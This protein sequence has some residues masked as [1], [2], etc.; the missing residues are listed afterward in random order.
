MRRLLVALLLSCRAEPAAAPEPITLNGAVRFDLERGRF[1]LLSAGQPVMQGATADVLVDDRLLAFDG[2]CQRRRDGNDFF[3]RYADVELRLHFDVTDHIEVTLDARN[4]GTS[5]V[6]IKRLTPVLVDAERGGKLNIGEPRTLR[7]LEN[8]RFIAIDQTAQLEAGDAPRFGLAAFAPIELRGNSVSNWSQLLFDITTKRALVSGYLTAERAIP[9]IGVTG[10]E[11]WAAESALIFHGK[12][13]APGASVASERLYLDLLPAD[14][15]AAMERYADAL[16]AAN[17]AKKW[18]SEIPCG[19]NSWSGGGGTGGHGQAI[20]ESIIL[21][22]LDIVKRELRP[23]GMTY[24]QIDD[25]W[26]RVTGDWTWDPTK[27]PL[28]GAGMAKTIADAGSKPGLWIAPFT[29][30]PPAP[31]A[32]EHPDWLMRSEE[33]VFGTVGKDRESLDLSNPAVQTHL[34]SVI[35]QIE[36]DGFK[37][38]KADFTYR[39]LVGKHVADPELT[40]VEAFRKGWRAIRDALPRDVFLLGIGL[41]GLHV[42]VADGM[43]MT[44]DDG[45]KWDEASVDDVVNAP[46]ALKGS[47]RTGARRWFYG[48]RA[49]VAHQDLI[50]FRSWPTP[51]VPKLTLDEA[52]T[53][54]TWVGLDGGIVEIGDKLVDL[55][56]EHLDILR[57]L[58][59]VWPHTSRPIDVL[60]R[61]Y[62]ERFEQTIDAPIGRYALLGLFH[63]GKNRDWST[64][65]PAVLSETTPREHQ[66]SCEKEC[67]AWE[68]WTESF[69]GRR[70]GPFTV[71]VP[72]KSARVVVLRDVKPHPQLLATNRHITMGATDHAPETWK[73]NT[74]S[75]SI[76]AVAGFEYHLAFHVPSGLTLESVE[77]GT[78]TQEGEIARVKVTAAASAPLPYRL[79]FR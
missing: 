42:G 67:L 46:R 34:R 59:P 16:A 26:Q 39:A 44:L 35:D 64:H 32:K 68:F 23:F 31:L 71:S 61:D 40:N 6:T 29:V 57:R 17:G 66:V 36:R 37:W 25:G 76:Q 10:N 3:C 78:F 30:E 45:P 69:L 24:F 60:L 54:A 22:G 7:I 20:D 9:T 27:F 63:W 14:P 19:W 58:L 38:V 70:T 13:I 18:A 48:N 1:D 56:P 15:L 47:V 72:P 53:F 62:P 4:V 41:V 51:E 2:P 11:L 55:K 52:R 5:K 12:P 74:L 73:D 79:R 33:G 49:Y 21:A 65:P 8:G 28:G 43:R 50:F 75:G 77:G